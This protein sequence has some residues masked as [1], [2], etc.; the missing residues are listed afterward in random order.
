MNK[1][2][3]ETNSNVLIYNTIKKRL[4]K[5]NFQEQ[6]IDYLIKQEMEFQ[7][8]PNKE[9]LSKTLYYDNTLLEILNL[10]IE[11]GELEFINGWYVPKNALLEKKYP[12][13]NMKLAYS[14]GL[15]R[16][17]DHYIDDVEYLYDVETSQEIVTKDRQK[18]A[19]LTGDL[20]GGGD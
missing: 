3:E 13:E 10:L 15:I 1:I 5:F 9:N 16:G 6:E 20:I 2:M 19:I 17:N 11:K 7:N 14:Y 8:I 4:R 12:I 18:R